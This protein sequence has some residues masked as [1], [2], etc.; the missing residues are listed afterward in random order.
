MRAGVSALICFVSVAAFADQVDELGPA[1]RGDPSYKVRAQAAIVLGN[2]KDRRGVPLLLGALRDHEPAVR[3][4]AAS[5]LGRLGDPSALDGLRASMADVE[6]PVRTAAGKA[7]AAIE[8]AR[9]SGRSVGGS[10]VGSRRIALDVSPTMGSMGDP[11]LARYAHDKLLSHLR[12]LRNVTLTPEPGA[13]RYFIDT[14]IT[15][16]TAV[17]FGKGSRVNIECDVSVIIATYPEHSM[18]MTASVGGCLDEPNDP[19]G[20]TDAKNF[21]LD[22]AAKQAAEKV[23]TYL[24]GVR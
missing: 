16:L 2:L 12:L 19:K 7:I 11:K 23:Q 6:L 20:I 15:K 4:V 24:K 10:S 8:A 1:L 14:T 18:K 22:D 3:I 9:D 13:A 21:C 17:T 5:S